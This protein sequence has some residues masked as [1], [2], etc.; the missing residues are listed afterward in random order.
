MTAGMTCAVA[1]T[2]L[3]T[4]ID[5]TTGYGLLLPGLLLFG[6]ALGLVYAPM[7]AAAMA[8]MPDAKAGIASGV[9]AMNRT[10]A[11]AIVLALSG[12]LFQ[13][14]ELEQRP[15]VGFSAAFA[16]A[17]AATGWLLAG[18]LAV[19]T[20]LTWRYVRSSGGAP[21][22]DEHRLHHRRFHL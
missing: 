17:L 5:P 21:P 10:L 20:V 3:L 22:V 14:V 13:H 18:V 15:E 19:G 16:D 12:A 1:G 9:L 7:S 4:R 6:I 8:A 2:L 11:G